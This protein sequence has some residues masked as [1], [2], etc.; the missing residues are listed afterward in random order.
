M[1]LIPAQ[2]RMKPLALQYSVLRAHAQRADD[3]NFCTTT[4]E[5]ARSAVLSAACRRADHHQGV[6]PD[7]GHK[8]D[9]NIE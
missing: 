5:A 7:D 2:G 1:T 6:H 8:S 9:R 4:D 3:I